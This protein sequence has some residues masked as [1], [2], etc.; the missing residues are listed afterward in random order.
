MTRLEKRFTMPDSTEKV[1]F[2]EPT[3]EGGFGDF[4][5][6][7]FDDG[8]KGLIIVGFGGSQK[9]TVLPNSG[10]SL[11][12]ASYSAVHEGFVGV[13]AGDSENGGLTTAHLSSNFSGG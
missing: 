5:T 13:G 4:D 7:N 9:N 8:S 12:K 3:M 2:F 10:C 11:V 1:H 6:G